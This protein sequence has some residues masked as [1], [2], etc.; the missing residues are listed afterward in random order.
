MVNESR[1]MNDKLT[2]SFL[3]TAQVLNFNMFLWLHWI[4]DVEVLVFMLVHFF[5]FKIKKGKFPHVH[6]TDDHT[7]THFD[8]AF[9]N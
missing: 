9:L 3:F 5:F 6:A 4:N 1:M 8:T 2:A 7:S